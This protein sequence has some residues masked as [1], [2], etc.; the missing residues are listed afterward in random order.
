MLLLACMAAG[1][2]LAADAPTPNWGYLRR[3]GDLAL[4]AAVRHLMAPAPW[5][6]TYT[7]TQLPVTHPFSGLRLTVAR[8]PGQNLGGALFRF[9]APE[10]LRGIGVVSMEGRIWVHVPGRPVEDATPELLGTPLPLLGVPLIVLAATETE[11]LFTREIVGEFGDVGIYQLEPRYDKGPG[12]Q[13]MKLAL[14]K[15]TVTLDAVQVV[16]RQNALVAGA[17]WQKV[18]LEQ[19]LQSAQQLTLRPTTGD[20]ATLELQRT[21]LHVGDAAGPLRFDASALQ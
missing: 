21:E 18:V 19:G 17:Q 5:R 7:E 6:A 12:L 16:D 10:C 13:R 1:T 15:R 3:H 4:F 14:Q 8:M 9:E 2:G 11:E 20:A